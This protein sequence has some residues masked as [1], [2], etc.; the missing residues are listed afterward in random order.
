TTCR[1]GGGTRRFPDS[2]S[3]SR[4]SGSTCSATACV[5][6]SIR[7]AASERGRFARKRLKGTIMVDRVFGMG[8]LA[9]M[10]LS[11][12]ATVKGS[13]PS[14]KLS[15]AFNDTAWDG[16]KIPDGMQCAPQGGSEPASP[17]LLVSGI[18][19]NTARLIVEFN[20]ESY[21]PLSKDG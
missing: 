18:P 12:C 5:M 6:S 9:V 8:L 14:A 3:T 20:D 1:R 4:F 7:K 16:T 17:P 2:A 10:L 11:G 15:V 13:V 21:A 19:E